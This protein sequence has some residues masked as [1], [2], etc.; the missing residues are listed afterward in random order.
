M[1]RSGIIAEIQHTAEENG[2]VPLGQR[3]FEESIGIP[4]SSWRGRYWRNWSEAV[5]AAGLV[6]NKPR[7]RHND[8]V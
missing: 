2:G 3:R 5:R 8:L 4:T 1:D 6:Q 7:E